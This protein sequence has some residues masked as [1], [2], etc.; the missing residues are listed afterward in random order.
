M[1]IM[2]MTVCSG[3]PVALRSCR[4]VVL[5]LHHNKAEQPLHMQALV[6]AAEEQHSLLSP[7]HLASSPD[8]G[9]TRLLHYVCVHPGRAQY[10]VPSLDASAAFQLPIEVWCTSTPSGCV[11]MYV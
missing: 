11:G 5:L 2:D 4:V 7:Q 1:H 6:D 8:Q 9:P 3:W 10:I